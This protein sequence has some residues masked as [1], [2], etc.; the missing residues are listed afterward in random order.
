MFSEV[1][2]TLF[3]WLRYIKATVTDVKR[4]IGRTIT[5]EDTQIETKRVAYAIKDAGNGKIGVQVEY[6]RFIFYII[7]SN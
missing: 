2:L 1:K 7:H 4:V 6:N 5:E 3:Q